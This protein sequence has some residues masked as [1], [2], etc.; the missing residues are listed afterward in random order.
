MSRY[1]TGDFARLDDLVA[2]EQQIS[3]KPWIRRCRNI[4]A[5][6]ASGAA[7]E[8]KTQS[9]SLNGVGMVDG[10][11]RDEATACKFWTFAYTE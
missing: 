3:N 4:P 6:G 7:H 8:V 10:L 2:G 5:G 1:V 9:R 11:L